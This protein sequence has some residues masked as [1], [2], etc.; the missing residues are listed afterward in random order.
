M[1]LIRRA[2]RGAFPATTGD[3]WSIPTNGS[4]A[5]YTAAGVPVTE[6]TALQLGVVYACVRI[7]SDAVSCL[8]L[9]AVKLDG[10]TRRVITSPQ[11]IA[12]PFGGESN[13]TLPTIRE[14]ISALMV[15]A[16]LRGN[17]FC[18][19]T[20]RE[21][22]FGRPSRLVGLHPDTV[23]VDV[24]D[25]ARTYKVNRV[26]VDPADMIH[27]PG[28][29]MPGDPVGLSVLT[30]ARQSI[31]LSLAAEE[32]G[33]RFFGS[34]A[35][36]SGLIEIPG[37]L[38]KDKARGVKENF[39]ASHSGLRHAHMI[40]VLTGGAKFTPVSVSPEDAQFL[41]TR[42][43]QNLDLAMW[44]GIPP[45]MLGQVDRTTSWGKGIEEQTL[46]FLKFTLHAWIKR[47]EDAFSSMLPQ[48]QVARLNLDAL[49]RPDTT[50]RF[51][52][53]LVARTASILTPDEIRAKENCGPLPNGQ[54]TDAFA[55]LNSAH[56]TD[57]GWNPSQPDDE[58]PDPVGDDPHSDE[59]GVTS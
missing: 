34:G 33:A 8:P 21:R 37:D 32:F 40:G 27:I 29:R 55:P 59:P 10:E 36:L 42:A 25:G 52:S 54:G 43:A 48:P 22:R 31:G 24:K 5:A 18:L 53:Y 2:V 7:L 11:I 58:E 16:L 23:Q 17:G 3:P 14:G 6:E 15:S 13:P 47:V 39:E 20:D 12:D 38:D 50:A 4:L 49:L 45:H 26:P 30:Y 28:M 41:G 35:H 44:Y 1:S 51:N 46:G 19:I 57:P 56:T 9:Q